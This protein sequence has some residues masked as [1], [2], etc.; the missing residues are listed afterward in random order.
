MP[1]YSYYRDMLFVL[2][3]YK[4]TYFTFLNFLILQFFVYYNILQKESF[5]IMVQYS[6][7]EIRKK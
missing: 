4:K 1:K 3:V 7:K 5:N 2:L 6:K